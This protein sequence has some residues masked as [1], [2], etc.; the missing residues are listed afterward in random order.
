MPLTSSAAKDFKNAIVAACQSLFDEPVV[1]SFGM[2]G[3]WQPEDIVMV[4]RV[5]STQEFATMST[6]RSREET[7]T[8]DVSV[9]CARGGGPEV[10][11]TCSDQ[12]YSLLGQ[13]EEYCRDTNPT[14]AGLV[15]GFSVRYCVLT[16]HESNGATDPD[17]LSEGRLIEVDATFTAKY[18]ISN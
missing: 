13:L 14:L 11:Q 4:G 3:S 15:E 1:V 8:V 2:P 6:N 5:T 9:M 18:R 17:L 10:E 16:S 12:A 7:L